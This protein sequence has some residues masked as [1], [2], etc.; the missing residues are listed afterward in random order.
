MAVISIVIKLISAE[1]CG[2]SSVRYRQERSVGVYNAKWRPFQICVPVARFKWL[3]AY[4]TSE[5]LPFHSTTSPIGPGPLHYW[6]FTTTLRHTSLGR[7]LLDEWSARRRIL[8][9]KTHNSQKRQTSMALAGFEPTIA[10]I[11]R[12]QTHTLDRAVTGIIDCVIFL[13]F[14]SYTSRFCNKYT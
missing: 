5:T 14:I 12:S 10:A 7:A 13:V 9:L 6:H 1:I 11:E 4:L 3:T 8:Y 2:F